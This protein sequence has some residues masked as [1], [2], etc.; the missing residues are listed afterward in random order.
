V[1]REGEK[2]EKGDSKGGDVFRVILMG[3]EL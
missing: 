1:V 2:L 3:T